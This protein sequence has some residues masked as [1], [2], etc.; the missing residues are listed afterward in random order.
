[1]AA[2][3]TSYA[4]A[5][6]RAGLSLILV[7]AAACQKPA[8][9]RALTDSRAP[10]GY[11]DGPVAAVA[12]A[13]SPL[14]EARARLGRR[15]F[16][17]KRLSRTGTIA[18]ASCHRQ[19]HAFADRAAV[20]TGVDGR[21]GTRNAPALVNRAWGSSFFWDGRA[22]SLERLVGQPI[23]NPLEMGL[24]LGDAVGVVARDAAYAREFSAAFDGAP[25]SVETLQRALASFVRTLVSGGS[26]YDRH[27]RGDDAHFGPAARR[28]EALFSSGKAGCFRCHPGGPL[29][30]GGYFNNGTYVAG[31]DPGR[32]A[33]TGRVGDLGK[34][35]V[36]TLRNVGASAP[37]MH[38][39]SLAT[40][41]DV[42][43]QYARGGRGDPA[44]DPLIKP[45][46]LSEAEK[47][48]IVAF[49]DSLTDADFLS[50]PRYR[51]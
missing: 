18:C 21:T 38:D 14:T 2:A 43:D 23:E 49:L 27:L 7:A 39:G 45:L 13:D 25:P 6:P 8:S 3:R 44:T 33:L 30:N 9:A 31:G 32:Q 12:P 47:S 11:A 1:V 5:L 51:P 17:D 46:S 26:P 28:G 19:E 50:D 41:R 15:L 48:D 16:Y 40:L 42:V 4:G 24:R 22:T 20:S 37:Y 36:P 35:K 34:F 10:P 29:T